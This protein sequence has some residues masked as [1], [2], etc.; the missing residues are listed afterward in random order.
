LLAEG[1]TEAT[2]FPVAA[3]RLAE[4]DPEKYSSFEA[5]GICTIDAV[6]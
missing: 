1:A 4:L 6:N 3:R 2:A 5:L